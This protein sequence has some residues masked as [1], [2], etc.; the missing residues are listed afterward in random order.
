MTNGITIAVLVAC[1]LYAV[2]ANAEER[3]FPITR[4]VT[5][6][7]SQYQSAEK[8]KILVM[9]GHE[10]SYGGTEYRSLKERDLM[11]E[12][13]DM[14]ALELR[15]NP[16]FEVT[17]ARDTNTWNVVLKSYFKREWKK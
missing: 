14:L 2:D 3:A 9:P 10:P 1:V 6:L 13:G 5:Q 11:V 16:R 4:T 7:Q 8:I 17:V 12:L 15:H